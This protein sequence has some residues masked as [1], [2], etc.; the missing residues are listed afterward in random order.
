MYFIHVIVV[1]IIF[2]SLFQFWNPSSLLLT[3]GRNNNEVKARVGGADLVVA[4]SLT[5][6]VQ[7]C[8]ATFFEMHILVC[9][10]WSFNENLQT[11]SPILTLTV[12]ISS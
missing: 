7:S 1:I 10:L 4:L 2:F 11:F 6:H 9:A 5:G 12:N 3:F 8:T